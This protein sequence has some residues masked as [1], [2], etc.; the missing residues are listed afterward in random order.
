M[1]LDFQAYFTFFDY[2]I[3][4]GQ[5]ASPGPVVSYARYIRDKQTTTN[6]VNRSTDG[7]LAAVLGVKNA[8]NY[9][10]T[11][12]RAPA[13]DDFVMAKRIDGGSALANDRHVRLY[14]TASQRPVYPAPYDLGHWKTNGHKNP[15][16]KLE[17]SDG[18]YGF[19]RR[20]DF[21]QLQAAYRAPFPPKSIL[22]VMKYVT[23]SPPPPPPPPLLSYRTTDYMTAQESRNRYMPIR[24]AEE[25]NRYLPDVVAPPSSNSKRF[26]NKFGPPVYLQPPITAFPDDFMKPPSPGARYAMD[27]GTDVPLQDMALQEESASVPLHTDA[28]FHS[29]IDN[30]LYPV[31]D[32]PTL[33]RAKIKK[34]KNKRPISVMLD[35]YPI[36]DHEQDDEHGKSCVKHNRKTGLYFL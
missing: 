6:P 3:Q 30:I 17:Y 26:R 11:T 31:P 23:G 21:P 35:I 15:Y 19:G 32:A 20:S 2:T 33:T 25:V 36:A 7:L 34:L 8:E 18:L 9:T 27:F 5:T 13:D 28:V 16:G 24:P 29:P 4:S 10:S 22:D 1:F 14:A 12:A